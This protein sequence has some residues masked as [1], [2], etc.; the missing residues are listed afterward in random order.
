MFIWPWFDAQLWDHLFCFRHII[1]VRISLFGKV[2]VHIKVWLRLLF[3]LRG[4]HRH[5]S[6]KAWV[7]SGNNKE[8][9][10]HT[11]Q[12]C[13]IILTFCHC[14]LVHH[15]NSAWLY[16]KLL[17]INHLS[18]LQIINQSLFW[19]HHF[20]VWENVMFLSFPLS[21]SM[22]WIKELVETING[23]LIMKK[24]FTWSPNEDTDAS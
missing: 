19:I 9:K 18:H 12:I 15:S 7:S 11:W 13:L 17:T 23:K 10:K 22:Y 5:F 21:F 1:R 2:Y 6:P 16:L 24:D 14:Y 8:N 4:E 3:H 20:E